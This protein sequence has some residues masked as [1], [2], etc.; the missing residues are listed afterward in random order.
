MG[1]L[2]WHIPEMPSSSVAG[3]DH[4][5]DVRENGEGLQDMTVVD[6]DIISNWS[7]S[8][9]PTVSFQFLFCKGSQY[10]LVCIFR[11]HLPHHLCQRSTQ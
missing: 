11:D 4:S 10:S 9:P 3:S 2:A 8:P 7:P 5:N 1:E 6:G